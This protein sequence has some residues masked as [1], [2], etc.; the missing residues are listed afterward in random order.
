MIMHAGLFSKVVSKLP[1]VLDREAPIY[2]LA[3]GHFVPL[4]AELLDSR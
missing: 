3:T 1:D 2:D 4:I